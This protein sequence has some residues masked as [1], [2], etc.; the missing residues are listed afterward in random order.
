MKLNP[1]LVNTKESIYNYFNDI[2]NKFKYFQVLVKD[3]LKSSQQ[4]IEKDEILFKP[5]NIQTEEKDNGWDFSENLNPSIFEQNFIIRSSNFI[6]DTIYGEI[7]NLYKEKNLLDIFFTYYSTYFLI[8][9]PEEFNSNIQNVKKIIYA[10]TCQKIEKEQSFYYLMNEELRSGKLNRI[11]KYISFIYNIKF[12]I[13]NHVLSTYN[14]IAYRG[15]KLDINFIQNIKKGKIIYNP[16]FW[17]CS[18]EKEIAKSFI[19]SSKDRRNV[20]LIVK[21]NSDNNIDIDKEKLSFY[22]E[23]EILIFPFSSFILTDEPKL[24]KDKEHNYDYYEIYLEYI[25]ENMMD[26]K[27]VNIKKKSLIYLK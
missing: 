25:K 4:I 12:C 17:A 27:V 2:K 14:D 24:V 3:N 16:C 10:W 22:D 8:S 1:I 26:D 6:V 13:S 7:Y 21:G 5:I 9:C 11:K 23:K 15:T 18:K 20:L 19:F